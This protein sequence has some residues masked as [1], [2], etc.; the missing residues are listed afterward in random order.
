MLLLRRLIKEGVPVHVVGI[1][2][3]W[4]TANVP[5]AALDKA[6]VEAAA[7]DS[8]A[9]DRTIVATA[10]DSMCTEAEHLDLSH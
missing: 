10:A 3:H 4:S 5:S 1:Q 9:L 6:I 2:G 8:S 7:V